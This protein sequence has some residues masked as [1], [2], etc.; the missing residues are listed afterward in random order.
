LLAERYANA[1][2]IK[3]REVT[4]TQLEVQMKLTEMGLVQ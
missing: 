1:L 4:M 3:K 2:E